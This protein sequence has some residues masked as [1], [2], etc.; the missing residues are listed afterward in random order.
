MQT[1]SGRLL[2]STPVHVCELG[3]EVL[4][5]LWTSVC[6]LQRAGVA[7]S[8]GRRPSVCLS[9]Q[10]LITSVRLGLHNAHSPLVDAAPVPI[11]SCCWCRAALL[12]RYL[13]ALSTSVA[14]IS[15]LPA[16]AYLFSSAGD[17]YSDSGNHMAGQLAKKLLFI[18]HNLK[19]V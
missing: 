18:K 6:W 19:Y 11:P 17:L 12:V 7:R 15:F 8:V 5:L 10:G 16:F 4:L 13:S 1:R 3:S 9:I 2:R 14:S